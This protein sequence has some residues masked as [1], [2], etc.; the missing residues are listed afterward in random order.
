MKQ[1][2]SNLNSRQAGFQL[3][4]TFGRVPASRIGLNPAARVFGAAAAA[5]AIVGAGTGPVAAA[6]MGSSAISYN[7]ALASDYRFRG[8]SQTFRGYALQGGI[9]WLHQSGL[10][11]GTWASRVSK[12]QF[13][14]S[15]GME[16]DL[17]GGYKFPIGPSGWTGDVGLLQYRYPGES[18]YNTLEAYVGGTWQWLSLKYSHTISKRYFGADG[19]RGTGYLDVTAT[20]PVL[21]KINL[22]GHFGATRGSGNAPDYTDYRLGATYDLN[23]YIL[24]AS[25]YKASRSFELTKFDFGKSKNLGGAGLVFSIG[26]TF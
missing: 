23:G 2:T 25:L 12:S 17:Y 14:G 6:D 18:R 4:R 21:D 9:D 26:R 22:I 10:Y 5:A 8:I 16:W 3:A 15:W 7:A 11:L 1:Q 24:G 20:Y 13:L 19:G